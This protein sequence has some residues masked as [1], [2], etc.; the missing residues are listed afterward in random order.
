MAQAVR[1][2]TRPTR[3]DLGRHVAARLN[4]DAATL[5]VVGS[6]QLQVPQWT[7]DPKLRP[8]QPSAQAALGPGRLQARE[9]MP[10]VVQRVLR[11]SGQPLDVS[12][13]A[14]MEL[15]FG[16]DFSRVRIHSD[17]AAG[18]SA[19]AVNALA[20]TVGPHIVMAKGQ[21]APATPQGKRLLAHELT[22]VVQQ[23]EAG[24]PA[25][26][27]QTVK[28][29]T[30]TPT[31]GPTANPPGVAAVGSPAV[32][33]AEASD[34][35]I[36]SLNLAATAKA[37]AQTLKKKHPAISFTSGRRSVHDQAHAMASNIVS[38]GNRNW[39]KDTYVSASS[40]QQWVDKNPKATTVEAIT[41]GLE[42]TM[43]G[44]SDADL[45]K[46]SKHLSGEAF[47]VQ[48]QKKDS[49]AIKADIKALPGLSKFLD[50]EG[51]LERWHAQFKLVP[52]ITSKHVACEQEAD[53]VAEQIMR[54]P[55][56]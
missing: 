25:I 18:A 9:A 48:P 47:D 52:G 43:N 2:L 49:D 21:Y 20:Y 7:V 50:S 16:H 44:M 34:A 35:A 8:S 15:R 6:R 22:H 51:G 28:G 10:P 46:V 5:P 27:R 4:R 33:P 45:G 32:A 38:G 56:A 19:D 13:L 23:R 53:A 17:E 11:S 3:P 36:D 41:K 26:Q 54:M 37:G 12:T 24:R 1:S 29:E 55:N 40:L 30:K 14:S 42:D 31:S 39:I